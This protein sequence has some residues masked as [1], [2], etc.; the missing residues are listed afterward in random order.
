VFCC[1]RVETRMHQ[2][3][4]P[5]QKINAEILIAFKREIGLQTANISLSVK[6]RVVPREKG[7]H[8]TE[9]LQLRMNEG[10]DVNICGY[11]EGKNL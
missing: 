10:N 1:S 6:G 3:R 11:A 7:L 5:R 4:E 9:E 8:F 2:Q